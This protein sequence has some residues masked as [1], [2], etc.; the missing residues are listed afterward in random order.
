MNLTVYLGDILETIKSIEDNTYSAIVT[1][2]PY[3][4]SGD[5]NME[6]VLR[7]WLDGTGYNHTGK[8]FKN[9]E[10]DEFVPPPEVWKE[11]YRVSK[12][13]A[14]MLVYSGTRTSDIM[15]VSVRL[16]GWQKF[17]ELD[18][19][20]P[21][22]QF[23]WIYSTAMPKSTNISKA[24][25]KAA[26][27]QGEII[28]ETSYPDIRNGHGR[29]YGSSLFAREDTGTIVHAE[30]APVTDT[31]REWHGYGTALNPAHEVI[32]LFR[33]PK[34][35]TFLENAVKHGTGVL[36]IAKTRIGGSVDGRWPK[37]V[38]LSCCNGSLDDCKCPILDVDEQTEH[39]SSRKA[40]R[41]AGINGNL[42]KS[43]E[44]S[45]TVRGHDDS[46]SKSR[47]F[48]VNKASTRERDAGLDQK[49]PHP[50]VKPVELSAYLAAMVVP[51]ETYLDT[52]KIAVPFSGSGSEIIG[53]MLAG[54]RNIDG[55]EQS[56]IY[57]DVTLQ[58]FDWW[59]KMV[60]Q[61]NTNDV[62][63]IISQSN[64]STNE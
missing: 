10:W 29:E 42:F 51:P 6:D 38:L 53:A 43:P 45:S 47:F 60:E 28:K 11:L 1:D 36:N 23:S 41:G 19:F 3:G 62:K 37:N 48:Y 40:H 34:E 8:G 59:C 64:R 57:A 46:G 52:A 27:F 25:D 7:G 17:D 20:G 56:A 63:S 50:T 58:R 32:M 39:S 4:L 33:K 5:P 22:N 21:I 61:L 26:G 49:N 15:G 35:G 9:S 55:F 31:A 16:G 44:Y 24:A 14:I 30:R 18:V 12:P 2:P 54:W 13:G